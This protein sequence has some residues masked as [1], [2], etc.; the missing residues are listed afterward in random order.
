MIL[1]DLIHSTTVACFSLVLLLGIAVI[2]LSF[3]YPYID[4]F[5]CFMTLAP[6][7]F[8]LHIQTTNTD[9]CVCAPYTAA[10][11]CWLERAADTSLLNN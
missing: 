7:L 3:Y 11:F 4:R 6:A 8:G 10:G 2:V 1:F 5:H 9:V